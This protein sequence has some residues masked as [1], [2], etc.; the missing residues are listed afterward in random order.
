MTLSTRM[1]KLEI[2][3]GVRIVE[4]GRKKTERPV[5]TLVSMT[6]GNTELSAFESPPFSPNLGDP[7]NML[8]SLLIFRE[9]T[10]G[11]L[12]SSPLPHNVFQAVILQSPSSGLSR[13]LSLVI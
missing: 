8:G 9:L 1:M 5:R 7:E 13:W 3:P 6:L 2:K 10:T 12:L 11:A 4:K